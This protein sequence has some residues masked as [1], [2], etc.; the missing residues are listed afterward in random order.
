MLLFLSLHPKLEETLS[1]AKLIEGTGISALGLHGRTQ[2]ERNQHQN[3][4]DLIKVI[5]QNLTI[6]VIA[7][8]VP[9]HILV[10]L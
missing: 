2:R 1:L 10:I 4:N 8:F 6:P 7:K 9:H 3:H 5:A